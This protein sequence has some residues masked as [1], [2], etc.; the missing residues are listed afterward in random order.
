MVKGFEDLFRFIADNSPVGVYF[1]LGGKFA[2]VNQTLARIFGYTPKELI[3]RAGPLDLTHPKDRH[4]VKSKIRQRL[5][6]EVDHVHYAFRGLRK[7]G[8]VIYC[9]AFG[10]RVEVKGS[11]AIVG[12]L[13]DVTE[14]KRVEERLWWE[15]GVKSAISD[16]ARIMVAF[17]S[18]VE[19][20]AGVVLDRARALTGSPHGF[21][22]VIDPDGKKEVR[23]VA[24][25]AMDGCRLA[26]KDKGIAVSRGRD[27]LY[28]GLW[29]HALNTGTAFY[30][31]LPQKHPAFRRIPEGHVPVKCFMAVPAILKDKVLG[32]VALANAPGGYSEKDLEAVERLVDLFALA[33]EREMEMEALAESEE[34][35]RVLTESS[36]T[37]IFI[38]QDGKYVFANE[39][40]ARLHGYSVEE[41][42][43]R[44]FRD[45]VYPGDRKKVEELV[46]RR[47]EGK[48]VPQE[49]EVR[50]LTKD[51]RVMWC[52]M[53]ASKITYKGRPAIMGNIVDVSHLK[54]LEIEL[55]GSLEK[56]RGILEGTIKA[57]SSTVEKRDPYTAGHQKRVAQLAR[58]L[59]GEMG[60]HG[61]KVEGVYMAGLVHDVGKISVPS[62]ILSK[63]GKLEPEEFAIIKKHPQVGYEIL[64][65]IE[66]P[67]PLA[68]IVLQHHEKWDGSGYPQGLK[69]GEILL[70][71]RILA[72]A[73]VVEAMASHRP[74]RPALGVEAALREIKEGKGVL[75]DPDV[76]DACVKVFT[77]GDF[78]FEDPGQG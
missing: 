70:E 52:R 49:Y 74:Y 44:D 19:E 60:L 8:A 54:A 30:T 75:Y 35:Y 25:E 47:L 26:I 72:V 10:S 69:D 4:L 7:D 73:D 57:F 11:V 33:L 15:L 37:G 16:V 67:W 62:E 51:G 40:F 68:E 22:S 20:I 41:I 64:K 65:D 71:A 48:G 27:G 45:L 14:K 43:G 53:L 63:P 78:K 77:Q 28:P 58:E 13:L 76:V 5:R 55:K 9:E 23:L 2:Y 38:Q 34:K 1:V 61:R 42:L 12:T 18:S 6:G 46:A 36:L 39:R 59:A 32:Q 21:A 3:N 24:T 17:S 31:N 56:L 50:R 29:G 66:F